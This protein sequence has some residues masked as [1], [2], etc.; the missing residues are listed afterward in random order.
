LHVRSRRTRPSWVAFV[1]V[2]APLVTIAP[3]ILGPTPPA[4]AVAIAVPLIP[5]TDYPRPA[6]S[7][8]VSPAGNDSASGTIANPLRTIARA[9]TVVPDGGTIVLRSGTY[10]EA[11]GAITD[12]VTIQ[13]FPHEQA[14]L[15]GRQIVTGWSA[16][17]AA[18]VRSGWNSG[19][20]S[21]CYDPL[22]VTAE[23]PAAG[24]PDMVFVDGVPQQ[25]VLSRAAVVAGTFFHDDAANALYL[26]TNPGGRQV[27]A[28][29]HQKALSFNTAG[30]AGS[31][32]RGV[33]VIGYGTNGTGTNQAMVVVDAPNVTIENA[34]FAWAATRG[35]AVYDT[36][37]LLHGLVVVNNGLQGI[38]V[39]HADGL[40]VDGVRVA[41][42]NREGFLIASS[43]NTTA[44]GLKLT[45][46]R[47]VVIRDSAFDDNDSTGLW[48]DVSSQNVTVVRNVARR[49]ARHGLF[50]EISD[51]VIVA[52]NLV[53]DNVNMGLRIAGTTNARIWNNT[54][55]DNL[56]T[57]IGVYETART[58]E[59]AAEY[60]TGITWD[61]HNVQIRN[62]ILS[63]SVSTRLALLHTGDWN[64]PKRWL[65]SD[66]ISALDGN[67]YAR[68]TTTLPPNVV[69]WA[70]LTP[71]SYATNYATAAAFR[72]AT[73]YEDAGIDVAGTEPL[74][75]DRTIGDYRLATSSPA[76]QSG[77]ALP[78]DIASAVG[79]LPDATVDRGTLS[80]PT[81]NI[82]PVDRIRV[83]TGDAAVLEGDSATRT[84]WFPVTLSAPARS[85]VTVYARITAGTATGGAIPGPGVDFNNGAGGL[86]TVTFAPLANGNTPTTR[87]VGVNVF[88]DTVSELTETI[89]IE[90]LR[91]D[92]M[93]VLGRTKGTGRIVNDEGGAL[94]VGVAG[95]A[96]TEG[97]VGVRSM[98]VA[99]T[100]SSTSTAP[101]TVNYRIVPV[102]ASG[103]P[104]TN[105]ANDV[106]HGSGALLTVE[107][108]AG[109]LQRSIIVAVGS[110]LTREG[111]ELWQVVVES[112]TGA[113]LLNTSAAGQIL[114][115]D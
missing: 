13:A 105:P 26:G 21:T 49:N 44:A 57:Q 31:A 112:A 83:S 114:D 100:L 43:P 52:S 82:V 8:Y 37:A 7:L 1:V 11:L 80:W 78:N 103:G 29:V 65:A 97:N 110:D 6:G 4:G 107:I 96:I 91:P 61:T 87:F 81:G 14:W 75:S 35:V 88:G 86:R 46:S 25:Q 20:C 50:V 113:Q 12:S 64:S 45:A 104:L 69:Y 39:D 90:L 2:T 58:N 93:A 68:T 94:R 5:D 101:V 19:L 84:I 30:A 92:G 99:V 48:V 54:F 55:V 24:L 28:T 34:V 72:N 47:D 79:V 63:T 10:R 66:M 40:I 36:D 17:G 51:Q 111:T 32:L 42:S 89:Q 95:G 76:I 102:T 106:D 22:Q 38:A 77:A 53:T 41:G 59:D 70:N 74:F 33:G 56:E 109:A 18:W 67:V 73:T 85:V 9:L 16:S 71:N 23:R 60:A 108:P 3:A 27:L 115:D 62:N 15:D 98:P